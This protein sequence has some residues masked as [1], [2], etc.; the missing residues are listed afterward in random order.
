MES[1]N[2]YDSALFYHNEGLNVFP[3]I[4]KDK[5]PAVKSWMFWMYD[6]Q[7]D[8][9]IETLFHL[10]DKNNLALVC[11]QASQNIYVVDCENRP[12]FHQF[13]EAIRKTIGNT[14][15]SETFRGGHIFL[16]SSEPVE[17]HKGDGYE[18]R[19]Q[20]SYV[21]VP[22]SIHPESSVYSFTS[23]KTDILLADSVPFVN[24]Q[25]VKPMWV[26][27]LARQ[28]FRGGGGEYQSR[29]EKDQAFL[30]SLVR[31]GFQLPQIE[32]FMLAASY[33]S[34]FQEIYLQNERRAKNWLE[35][36]FE[37][38]QKLAHSAEFQEVQNLVRQW[39]EWVGK[40]K[41]TGRT[42]LVDKAVFQ[43]HLEIAAKSGKIEYHASVRTIA[44]AAKVSHM[45]A[46][47]ANK[48]LQDL[49]L[50][51]E[52]YNGSK[53]LYASRWR[54]QG[55]P[56][57]PAEV[58]NSYTTVTSRTIPS[59]SECLFTVPDDSAVWEW[60]GLGKAAR[61]IYKSLEGEIKPDYASI[62]EASGR[63][64]TTLKRIMPKLLELGIILRMNDGYIPNRDVD[65]YSLERKMLV[66]NAAKDRKERHRKQR[67][68]FRRRADERR[69]CG[70]DEI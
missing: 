6:Q 58:P 55:N 31:A 45:T 62:V 57:K 16:R 44:E 26:P 66:M 49:G 54:L 9:D 18:I 61:A 29:S 27:R 42:G 14:A 11:G 64:I 17:Y 68:A 40:D 46:S 52:T 30:V 37:N 63:S 5:H 23:A 20:G 69:Y 56:L 22:P 10:N 25:F 13:A 35:R 7:Q 67:R 33:E 15:M 1:G 19:G 59:V 41:W 60:K 24:L 28:I 2:I 47:V 51:I 34:K 65:V 4:E 8:D 53:S 70:E 12:L 39:Q 38:A 3:A 36:S 50:V 43:A 32:K 21:L 48:R